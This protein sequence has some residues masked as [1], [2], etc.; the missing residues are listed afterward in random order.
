M[1]KIV[2]LLVYLLLSSCATTDY[3][4]SLKVNLSYDYDM[5]VQFIDADSNGVFDYMHN[6]LVLKDETPIYEWKT[7]QIKYKINK[8]SSALT[9]KEITKYLRGMAYSTEFIGEV[10][11]STPPNLQ[12]LIS[13]SNVENPQKYYCEIRFENDSNLSII[14]PASVEPWLDDPAFDSYIQ[15]LEDD[16][17]K[18]IWEVTEEDWAINIS[19]ADNNNAIIVH[20]GEV[21]AKICE[22][23]EMFDINGEKVFSQVMQGQN[24]LVIPTI[25]YENGSYVMRFTGREP[26]DKYPDDRVIIISR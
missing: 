24:K 19:M 18:K 9:E 26:W 11:D 7:N 25:N 10:S 8:D 3:V 5:L 6:K 23:V 22:T 20:F 1:K 12:G 21:I 14:A 15:K 16:L 13:I 2:L 17:G 4:K